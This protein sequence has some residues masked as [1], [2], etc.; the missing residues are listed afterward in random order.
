MLKSLL[1]VEPEDPVAAKVLEDFLSFMK[2]FVSLPL[3]IPGSSYANA[4]KVLNHPDV[5]IHDTYIDQVHETENKPRGWKKKVRYLVNGIIFHF[6]IAILYGAPCM[7][8][9]NFDIL[10]GK[11]KDFVNFTRHINRQTGEDSKW[12]NFGRRFLG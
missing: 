3:Y 11:D 12:N 1:N 6:Y 5:S 10:L 2:G 9:L 4:V 8:I 7:Y